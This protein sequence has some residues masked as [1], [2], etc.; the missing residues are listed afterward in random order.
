[1]RYGLAHGVH[2]GKGTYK[3][4]IGTRKLAR[5]S[6]G[7]RISGLAT[8]PFLA[9][10]YDPSGQDKNIAHNQVYEP[11]DKFHLPRKLHKMWREQN[12]HQVQGKPVQRMS[13]YCMQHQIKRFTKPAIPVLKPYASIYSVGNV[14]NI[15]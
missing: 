14:V 1:V 6:G 9:T 13:K 8:P 4:P 15:R 3:R 10:S 5:I 12:Q 11:V 2:R 7:I